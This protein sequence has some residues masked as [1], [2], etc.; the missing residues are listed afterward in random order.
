MTLF[1]R[2]MLVIF[3][4]VIPIASVQ[5]YAEIKERH[6]HVAAFRADAMRY[7]LSVAE[8]RDRLFDRARRFL[9]TAAAI[10]AVQRLDPQACNVAFE[11][12]RRQYPFYTTVGAADADGWVVCGSASHRCGRHINV[13]D[14]THFQRAVQRHEFTV[15]GVARPKAGAAEVLD[16][17][18]PIVSDHQLAGVIVAGLN[19]DSLE[20]YIQSKAWPPNTTL[21]VT[22]AAGMVVARAP[23]GAVGIG[24]PLPAR[25]A[26]EILSIGRSGVFE[27]PGLDG[28]P[29]IFGYVSGAGAPSQL[30]VIVGLDGT[31]L[32]GAASERLP[33]ALLVAALAL[34]MAAALGYHLIHRPVARLAQASRRWAD[35]DLDAR[36]RLPDDG[37][38]LGRVAHAAEGLAMRLQDHLQ[39][40]DL[41]MR[42]INH[43]TMNTMQLLSSM[44]GLQS[45]HTKHE[46]TRR[47]LIQARRR[48]TSVGLVFRRIFQMGGDGRVELGALLRELCH[49]L[50][51]ALLAGQCTSINVSAPTIELPG[52]TALPV[53][54]I[55]H[56]LVTNSLKYASGHGD[57]RID[58]NVSRGDDGALRLEV[59]DSGPGLPCGFD[60]A[61]SS[62][63]GLDIV[64]KLVW[65]LHGV[66]DYV[67]NKSGARFVIT[68]PPPDQLEPITYLTPRDRS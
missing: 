39:R 31:R 2:V 4:A 46:A 59:A 56:E 49:E 12:L 62:G 23:D 48:I 6:A 7:A 37:S 14:K 66:L 54:M 61:G 29:R 58:V 26:H 63:L 34:S 18:Y 64:A 19:L 33:L 38:D 9:L 3:A 13:A 21:T 16:V 41:L 50:S 1:A 30:S 45:Q 10:P 65:Q 25:I 17:A 32:D 51:T 15:G 68:I 11:D 57:L 40:T 36:A 44:L 47:Q 55:V 35:G 53:V 42:E 22:D 24:E 52:S 27:A 20:R 67:G 5:I 8:E 60:P 28:I 43:R